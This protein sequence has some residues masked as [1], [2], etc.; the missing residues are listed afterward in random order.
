MT[1][2]DALALREYLMSRNHWKTYKP[3]EVIY[4]HQEDGIVTE[5]TWKGLNDFIRNN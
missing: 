1:K 4:S 5:W 2:E 3:S